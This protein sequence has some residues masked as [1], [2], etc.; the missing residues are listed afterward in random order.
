MRRA[1]KRSE[2]PYNEVNT[3]NLTVQGVYNYQDLRHERRLHAVQQPTPHT[4]LGVGLCDVRKREDVGRVELVQV[5]VAVTGR[6]GEA[7]VEAAAAAAGDVRHYAVERLLVV[8]GFVESVVPE[9][10]QEPAAL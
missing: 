2:S 7:V 3:M 6:L 5:R 9:R 10:P 8:L 1:E 4:G